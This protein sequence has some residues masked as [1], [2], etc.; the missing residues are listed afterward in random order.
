MDINELTFVSGIGDY[1]ENK[2][3]IMSAAVAKWRMDHGEDLGNATDELS[4]VCPVIRAF[5]IRVNDAKWWK[6]DA[7]RTVVLRPFVDKIIGTADKDKLQARAFLV[8]DAAVR[9]FA[10][11]A[12]DAIGHT[13]DAQKL[14]TLPPVV[15]RQSANAAK[16]A[17]NAAYAAAY[18]VAAA[19]AAADAARS[20]AIEL[21]QKLCEI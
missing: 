7:E 8:A 20:A 2:A 6:D 18:A 11:M 15:D 21:L 13:E 17:A 3:C 16:A 19:D 10:P 1:S 14:R 12:L 5:A 9:S 4:C